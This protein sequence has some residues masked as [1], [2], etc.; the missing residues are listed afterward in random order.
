MEEENCH[1]AKRSLDKAVRVTRDWLLEAGVSSSR[2]DKLLGILEQE[3][4]D[5]LYQLRVFSQLPTFEARF[6]VTTAA[7]LRDALG[8]NDSHFSSFERKRADTLKDARTARVAIRERRMREVV[9]VQENEINQLSTENG[10][11]G[12]EVSH[13]RAQLSLARAELRTLTLTSSELRP[14]RARMVAILR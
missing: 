9:R 13:L 12:A 2:V 1:D 7:I 5:T 3:Q 4:V 14:W 11:L 8:L 6:A 10:L